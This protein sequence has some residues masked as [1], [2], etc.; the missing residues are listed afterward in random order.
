[1]LAF[2]IPN[3]WRVAKYLWS[4]DGCRLFQ[5]LK[6]ILAPFFFSK[7][8]Q[9]SVWVIDLQSNETVSIA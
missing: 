9:G 8:L 4:L 2:N 1:M 3:F 7:F 6:D 5:V